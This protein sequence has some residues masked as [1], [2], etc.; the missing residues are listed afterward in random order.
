MADTVIGKQVPIRIAEQLLIRLLQG[1]AFQPGELPLVHRLF[2]VQ[3]DLANR[4]AGLEHPSCRRDINVFE[5]EAELLFHPFLDLPG[6]A[7][8]LLDVFDLPVDHSAFAVLLRID[9]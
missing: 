2:V 3:L 1:A 6:N 5:R 7:G 9:L 8:G 4:A